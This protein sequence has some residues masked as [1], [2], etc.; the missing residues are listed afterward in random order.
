MKA[1]RR[2]VEHEVVRPVQIVAVREGE[3]HLA[4]SAPRRE[5]GREGAGG[6]EVAEFAR[7]RAR[8]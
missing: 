1:E 3:N 6:L 5:R 2:E 7:H 8:A 4:P